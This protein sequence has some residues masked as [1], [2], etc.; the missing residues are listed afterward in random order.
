MLALT[1][2][3]CSTRQDVALK[4]IAH[5][6]ESD[7]EIVRCNDALTSP[8]GDTS[9]C[10]GTRAFNLDSNNAPRVVKIADNIYM[11]R[12][13]T[14]R[15]NSPASSGQLQA[16]SVQSDITGEL[17]SFTF[18]T[19]LAA[20]C[21]T[22]VTGRRCRSITAWAGAT[23]HLLLNMS[24]PWGH[25]VRKLCRRVGHVPVAAR[26]SGA[27]FG[28]AASAARCFAMSR[29]MSAKMA[30]NSGSLRMEA[31]AGSKSR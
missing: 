13:A 20:S 28:R 3:Q 21:S 22:R 25:V 2:G 6:D 16:C 24:I 14:C 12:I 15:Y 19:H 4:R 31:S 10:G 30:L 27:S 9:K 11:T 1:A 18:L 7:V 23:C 26:S 29:S 17:R 5:D 8:R